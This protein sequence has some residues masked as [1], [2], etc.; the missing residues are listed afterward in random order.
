[1]VRLYGVDSDTV[2]FQ[3]VTSNEP[4]LC[5]GV[6][7]LVLSLGH[8]SVNELEGHLGESSGRVIPVGDC[9]CPRTAEEAVLEGLEAGSAI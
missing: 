4:V 2:Y 1:M 5:D 9:L 7:T 3:H 8:E 6:D